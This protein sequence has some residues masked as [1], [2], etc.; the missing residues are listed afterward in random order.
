MAQPGPTTLDLITLVLAIIGTVGTVALTVWAIAEWRLSGGRV[1]VT[2]LAA[3]LGGG[4]VAISGKSL[5]VWR[6][7]PTFNQQAFAVEVRSTGRLPV[8]VE[9]WAILCARGSVSLLENVWGPTLPHRLEAISSATWYLPADGVIAA[10]ASFVKGIGTPNTPIRAE[11]ILGD[12]RVVR[13]KNSIRLPD[14][15]VGRN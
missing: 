10:Q 14:S 15:F 9:K 7:D 8:T 3:A 2:L 13:S 5:D 6:T 4:G 11:V 12:G 1:R